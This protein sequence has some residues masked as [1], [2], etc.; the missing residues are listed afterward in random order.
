[1]AKLSAKKETVKEISDKF[2]ESDAV[3]L[4]DYRG[5]DVDEVT[6]LRRQ[7][8]EADIDYKVYKNT[9]TRRAVQ[10]VELEELNDSLVGPTAVAFSEEDVVSP[11]KILYNF[12][13][14]HEALEVKGGVIEGQVVEIEQLEELS[15][16]P[17]YDGLVS[18]LLS[19]LQAPIRDLAYVTK[20][21]AEEKEEA[22][23]E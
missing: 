21:V 7:L 5:L 8:R 18:M 2:R 14:E 13:K 6:E 20:A 9:L 17:D 16:L 19:V 4:V 10:D 3:V 12:A 23:E 15:K 11:A 1:M 22:D